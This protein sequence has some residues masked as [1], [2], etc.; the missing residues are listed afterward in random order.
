M[1]ELSWYATFLAGI[2]CPGLGHLHHAPNTFI[3]AFIVE[4]KPA[5]FFL[6]LHY[7]H[8]LYKLLIAITPL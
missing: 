1:S 7:T 2:S 5:K 3:A 6:D 4:A 8:R